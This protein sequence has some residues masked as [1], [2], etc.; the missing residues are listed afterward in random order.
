MNKNPNDIFALMDAMIEQ[1]VAEMTFG[2]APDMSPRAAGY[3]IIIQGGGVIPSGPASQYEEVQP[4]N[5]HEPA[6]EVHRIGN[7]VKV[8]AEIPGAD[9]ERIKVKVEGSTLI[10]DA[11]SSGTTH[12]LM[13]A[14]LPPVDPASMQMSYKN[15]V[16]EVTFAA[17][18]DGKADVANTPQK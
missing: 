17:S 1:M 16:L 12:N 9:R 15:G 3:R 18:N 5:S 11:D 8:V 6:P 10:I 2:M 7:E 13:S 14:E 4:H